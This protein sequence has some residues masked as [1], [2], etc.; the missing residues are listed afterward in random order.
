MKIEQKIEHVLQR[1]KDG[2][3]DQSMP[4]EDTDIDMVLMDCLKEVKRLNG[5]INKTNTIT[6]PRNLENHVIGKAQSSCERLIYHYEVI[7]V[8][9]SIIASNKEAKE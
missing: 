3:F 8:W 4:P 9:E 1:V 5:L 2:Y 7:N 6:L